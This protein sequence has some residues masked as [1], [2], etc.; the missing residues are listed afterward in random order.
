MTRRALP[1]PWLMYPFALLLAAAAPLGSKWLRDER[2]AP[3]RLACEL[4]GLTF[5]HG[6]GAAC[7]GLDGRG[8]AVLLRSV[9]R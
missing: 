5:E 9:R 6:T 3:C 8:E 2:E 1:S 4:A 7:V